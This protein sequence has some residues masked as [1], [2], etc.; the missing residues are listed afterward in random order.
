MQS[1]TEYFH[2]FSIIIRGLE[3]HSI[4]IG[5]FIGLFMPVIVV[6]VFKLLRKKHLQLDEGVVHELTV[7]VSDRFQ[8]V[9]LSR[10]ILI[11]IGKGTG[12]PSE[13]VTVSHVRGKKYAVKGREIEVLRRRNAEDRTIE[14]P[15]TVFYELF[16]NMEPDDVKEFSFHFPKFRQNPFDA[17]WN[18][19]DDTVKTTNQIPILITLAILFL[20]LGFGFIPDAA[21]PALLLAIPF[22]FVS[23]LFLRK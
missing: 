1:I 12:D 6:G 17:Y 8:S 11:K 21:Q 9:K 2:H 15:T 23:L 13:I 22:V 14:L 19:P 18:H 4:I 7:K 20:E 10:D 16:P 3:L 5:V